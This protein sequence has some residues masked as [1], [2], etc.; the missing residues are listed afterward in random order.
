[1]I[2]SAYLSGTSRIRCKDGEE[3]AL[4]YVAGEVDHDGRTLY[5]SIGAPEFPDEA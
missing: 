3:I 2:V 1:M 5:V 4:R